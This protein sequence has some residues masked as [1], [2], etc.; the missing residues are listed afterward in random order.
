MKPTRQQGAWKEPA[1]CVSAKGSAHTLGWRVTERAC[2]RSVTTRGRCA[3]RR[4]WQGR[5]GGP[6]QQEVTSFPSFRKYLSIF[7]FIDSL[8]KKK[9]KKQN[10]KLSTTQINIINPSLNWKD[11][12][13]KNWSS[14]LSAKG[15][16]KKSTPGTPNT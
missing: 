14:G 9:N 5:G 12:S 16:K 4:G 2:A 7:P 15:E 10:P 13:Q 6:R 11:S 1:Y 8:G 3:S